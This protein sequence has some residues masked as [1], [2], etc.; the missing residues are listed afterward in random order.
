MAIKRK[1]SNART[2]TSNK[3]NKDLNPLRTAIVLG[4]VEDFKR[5]AKKGSR[6][7][8]VVRLMELALDFGKDDIAVYIF[9]HV[10]IPSATFLET[11]REMAAAHDCVPLYEALLSKGNVDD[12]WIENNFDLILSYGSI[13]MVKRCG[14]DGKID[15]NDF[16]YHV[17]FERIQEL[18]DMGC[19]SVTPYSVVEMLQR[20]VR[21]RHRD[22]IRWLLE[23]FSGLIDKEK[24]A[25]QLWDCVCLIS[26]G[27]NTDGIMELLHEFDVL[28]PVRQSNN[29]I[30]TTVT[31]SKFL[32][33]L[34][35]I[36]VAA[37]RDEE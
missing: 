19:V 23:R 16:A 8:N 25:E 35:E 37:S 3:R 36:M 27:F 9:D 31:H 20:L 4:T 32:R 14:L 5:V 34:P 30:V 26:H 21:V 1:R 17:S 12:D 11:V 28:T 2:T 29:H 10:F 6:K 18:Y 13:K 7:I 33:S 15:I 24:H 22:G